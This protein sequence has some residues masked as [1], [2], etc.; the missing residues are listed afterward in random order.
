MSA[1]VKSRH[2]GERAEMSAKCQ[3]Q[4]SPRLSTPRDCRDGIDPRTIGFE[5]FGN[6][7]NLLE[8]DGNYVGGNSQRRLRMLYRGWLK[9]C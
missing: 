2:D 9:A 1:W 4:S 5:K 7:N 8:A 3:K 6:G